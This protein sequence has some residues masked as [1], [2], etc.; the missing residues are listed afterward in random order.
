MIGFF[1]LIFVLLSLSLGNKENRIL[2]TK[3][4]YP[5][6]PLVEEKIA[7]DG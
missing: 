3:R 5:G 6:K 2:F 4:T 7:K 1:C